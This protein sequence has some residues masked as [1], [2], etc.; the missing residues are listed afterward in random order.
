MNNN[1]ALFVDLG[2]DGSIMQSDPETFKAQV[3]DA[4]IKLQ[5]ILKSSSSISQMRE[6]AKKKATRNVDATEEAEN[7]VSRFAYDLLDVAEELDLDVLYNMVLKIRALADDMELIFDSRVGNKVIAESSAMSDKKVAS[8]TY[9]ALRQMWDSYVSF[10]KNVLNYDKPLPPLAPMHG[11][12][13]S[14]DG[15]IRKYLQFRY[16]GEVY[17]NWRNFAASV[18]VRANSVDELAEIANNNPELGIEVVE[19]TL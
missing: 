6:T 11:N 9:K 17:K 19:V 16:K 14:R 15:S 8:E 5:E 1:Q 7:E 18:G 4:A 12:Y 13:S 3:F 2:I 10:M